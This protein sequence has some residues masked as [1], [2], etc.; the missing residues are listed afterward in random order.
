MTYDIVHQLF[1]LLRLLLLLLLLMR[2]AHG[3]VPKLLLNQIAA[4]DDDDDDQSERKHRY[5]KHRYHILDSESR[6]SSLDSEKQIP[7]PSCT[8]AV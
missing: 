4:N 3:A 6:V 1:D 8:A 5:Q 7:L 2:F